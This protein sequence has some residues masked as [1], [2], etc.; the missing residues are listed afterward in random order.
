MYS[1]GSLNENNAAINTNSTRDFAEEL[2]WKVFR[3]EMKILH[4]E[5]GLNKDYV[6][7]HELFNE[8]YKITGDYEML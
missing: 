3:K 6:D 4:A 5:G 8:L 1:S 7:E 2:N